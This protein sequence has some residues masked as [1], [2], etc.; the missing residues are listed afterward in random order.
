MYHYPLTLLTT[1]M[2]LTTAA[3]TQ[4]ANGSAST[5]QGTVT[6]LIHTFRLPSAV[7]LSRLQPPQKFSLIDVMKPIWPTAPGTF[8]AF[9]HKMNI[10]VMGDID[11]FENYSQLHY[12]VVYAA[13]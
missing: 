8:Q 3:S 1:A 11:E 10:A 7:S 13:Y 4:P 12:V 2:Q 6:T 9:S 5:G